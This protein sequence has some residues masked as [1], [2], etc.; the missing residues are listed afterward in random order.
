M[1]VAWKANLQELGTQT[2]PIVATNI[3]SHAGML[4][5]GGRNGV[6][7]GI[8]ALTG[9]T[10]WS[11]SFGT[12]QIQCPGGTVQTLGIQGTPAYDPVANV[13][14]FED[15]VNAAPHA[16][17][18]ITLYKLNPANGATLGSVNITPG[19]L[20]GEID[21]SH[22]AIT[23]AGGNAYLGTGSTCDVASWRGRLVAVN[24][25]SMTLGNTFYPA[26]DQ[27]A[28]Y[29]G[30]GVW[31]WGGVAADAAGNVYTGAG[32]A[33]TVVAGVGP[34]APFTPAPS[35]QSGYAEHM[36][37]LTGDLSTVLGSYAVPYAF[38]PTA[39]DLDLSGTPVLFA[40]PGCP[41]LVAIQ[42]KAG[43]L[44]FYT[45]TNISAG[46]LASFT[47][48]EMVGDISY[49][50]NGTYS[51]LTGL[52]YADV[53]TAQGGSLEPPGMVAFGVTNCGAPSIV[54]HTQ[55]GADSYNIGPN[56][57]QPRSAPS[58]TAGNV[59]FVASPTAAGTSQLWA[60]DATTGGLLH[61]GQPVLTTAHLMRM[62]PVIDGNWMFVIDQGGDLY[63]LTIG[64]AAAKTQNRPVPAVVRKLR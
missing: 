62:P 15:G 30:G 3:G 21:F 4:F 5:V 14:Y 55:F 35:E 8:D 16:P 57:G 37:Q 51:P 18:T 63:A 32:N 1:H 61:G 47:F 27:G 23:L 26:Y 49:I 50:G 59:V 28:P 19:N 42:G 6:A 54:W 52:F 40:P 53:P 39:S 25:A 24:A 38:S 2:Q 9:T 34:R 7:Y 44:N 58:V 13:V 64:S 48:S 60:L 31:A 20:P 41:Q 12:E 56:D 43:Q 33:E 46:V 29:S 10:V 45:A 17:Q 11:Q 36:T 22:T